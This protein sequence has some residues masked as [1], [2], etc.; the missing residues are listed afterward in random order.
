MAIQKVHF[1]SDV[2]TWTSEDEV[3]TLKEYFE[4]EEVGQLITR[5]LIVRSMVL[6]STFGTAGVDNFKEAFYDDK[7]FF[8]TRKQWLHRAC[9]IVVNQEFY[10]HFVIPFPEKT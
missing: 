9:D 7:N 5:L 10:Y 4:K 3:K 2:N 1:K 6:K 8:D